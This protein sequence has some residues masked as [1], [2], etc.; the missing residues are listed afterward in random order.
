MNPRLLLI[1]TS[2]LTTSHAAIAGDAGK[3]IRAGHNLLEDR[4][5][6]GIGVIIA[7]LLIPSWTEN[8]PEK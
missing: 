1:L 5:S 4:M 2:L 8:R 3:H 6:G 7:I